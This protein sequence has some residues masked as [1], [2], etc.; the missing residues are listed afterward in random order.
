MLAGLL[1]LLHSLVQIKL[2]DTTPG[3]G[4]SPQP[5]GDIET[6]ETLIL[7]EPKKRPEGTGLDRFCGI[8]DRDRFGHPL[9]IENAANGMNDR[10][11]TD[12]GEDGLFASS[13]LA[14]DLFVRVDT[15]ATAVDGRDSQRP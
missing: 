8:L 9:G 10:G 13:L 6:Q 15:F 14:D 2:L 4:L 7:F 1:F 11:Y 5:G 3:R 12:D